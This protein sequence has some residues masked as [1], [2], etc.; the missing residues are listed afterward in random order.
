MPDPQNPISVLQLPIGLLQ[1]FG[2]L[3]LASPLW[4]SLFRLAVAMVE[5][6]LAVWM[7]QVYRHQR[8]WAMGRK[9]AV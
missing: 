1:I 8:V 3:P 4:Y 7:I 9:G 2:V 5:L 6:G